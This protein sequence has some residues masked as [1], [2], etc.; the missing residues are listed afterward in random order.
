MKV[1]YKTVLL[2]VLALTFNS[3]DK[4]EVKEEFFNVTV[5]GENGVI[6]I[7]PEGEV[8]SMGQQITITAS[9]DEGY[10]F[11]KWSNGSTDNPLV[12][13]VSEDLELTA[14][15][16]KLAIGLEYAGGIVFYIAPE[17]ID[18]DDD[19]DLDTGL[20]CAIEDQSSGIQWFNGSYTITN[21]TATAV[22][23]GQANTNKII[24]EQGETETNYAA[25][26]A[27]AYTAGGN[28]DWF[29]PSKDVLNLMYTNKATIN[30]TATANGGSSLSS[31]MYWSSTE[32]GDTTAWCQHFGQVGK[33]QY[34]QGKS[35]KYTVRAVRAF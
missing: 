1:F 19:G 21:A 8:F 30:T 23:T 16:K 10:L 9:A 31:S 3:C 2:V 35:D 34:S 6:T 12:I 7:S 15:I 4:D 11:E 13:E 22:G 17:P 25:G 33:N 5:S 14:S 20:L 29:L 24:K 32:Y 27:K 26:L 28:N 18:L